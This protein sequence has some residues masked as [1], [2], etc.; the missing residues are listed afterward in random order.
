[1]KQPI[2]E[3]ANFIVKVEDDK[4]SPLIIKGDEVYCVDDTDCKAGDIVAI[5]DFEKNV[6]FFQKIEN[7]DEYSESLIIGRA[8]AVCRPL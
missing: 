5:T 7:D 4:M 6:V 8:I 3:K 1:M 2:T